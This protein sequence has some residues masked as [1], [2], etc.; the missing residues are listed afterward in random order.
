M[1]SITTGTFL[2]ALAKSNLLSTEQLSEIQ[3]EVVAVGTD[4]DP[5]TVARSLIKRGFLTRW[6]AEQL[7]A[8]H[9]NLFLGKYKLLERIG[10]GGMGTVYKAEHTVMDRTVAL[11]VMAQSMLNDPEAVA[12]F[13]REVQAA[14][15]LQHP[16]IVSAYDADCVGKTHFLVME[17]VDGD[18]LKERLQQ[19]GRLSVSWVC[20][21]IRQAALGLQHAHEHGM[22]HRDIKP[23]NLLVTTDKTDGPPTVKILDMGLARFVSNVKEDGGLTKSGQV[24]GTPDYIAPEQAEDTKHADIRADI[25]S[26]G[27]TLFHLL[28]AQVPYQGETMMNKLMARIKN[29]APPVRSLRSDVPEA[30]DA[31]IAKMLETNPA[32][33]Q[34]TPAEVATALAPFAAAIDTAFEET[35]S[36]TDIAVKT[37]TVDVTISQPEAETG[38]SEL[39]GQLADVPDH[40]QQ[41]VHQRAR[42]RHRSEPKKKGSEQTDDKSSKR[43][44]LRVLIGAGCAGIL[45]LGALAAFVLPRDSTPVATVEPAEPAP[46]QLL[47]G[48]GQYLTE[49]D[50]PF[51]VEPEASAETPT[52][53]TATDTTSETA[54]P[55]DK[56]A[57]TSE[58]S[59]ASELEKKI[60]GAAAEIPT[61]DATPTVPSPEAAHAPQTLVVGVGE[62][63]VP[64]LKT[65]FEQ[66]GPGDTIL[67]RHRGP[68]EFNPIDLNGKTPLTIVG[69]TDSNGTDFWPIVRQ[70]LLDPKDETQP[71]EAAGLFHGDQMN[72]TL[73]K[74]HLAVAGPKRADIGSVFTMGNG[75]LELDECTVTVGVQGVPGD[76]IG[77][78]MPLVHCSSTADDRVELVLRRTFLRGQRLQTCLR[79]AGTTRL[80]ISGTQTT[81]AGGPSPWIVLNEPGGEIEVSLTNCTAYNVPSL[82]QSRAADE[83]MAGKPRV[84]VESQKCLF[85]GPYANKEPFIA[86]NSDDPTS[87]LTR[88]AADGTMRWHGAN[89]VFHRY[90]SYFADERVSGTSALRKW[91][92]LWGQSGVGMARESDPIFRV[93]PDGFELQETYARDLQPRFWRN[94]NRA[95]RVEETDI[96]ANHDDI[97][98]ALSDVHLRQLTPPELAGVPRG[99]ARQLRVHQE[100]GPYQTLEA[101][102]ADLRNGDIIEIADDGV[103]VPKRDFQDNPGTGIFVLDGK[104]ATVRAA[105]GRRPLII[106]DERPQE[107]LPAAPLFLFNVT[108]AS[109]E[110]EGLHFAFNTGVRQCRLIQ[111]NDAGA[112]RVSQCSL[113]DPYQERVTP[114]D[115]RANHSA[116]LH[117]SIGRLWWESNVVLRRN[118]TLNTTHYGGHYT[119]ARNCLVEGT[120]L[121][122]PQ[123]TQSPRPLRVVHCSI[124]GGAA[125]TTYGIGRL[126]ETEVSDSLVAGECLV[127]CNYAGDLSNLLWKGKNNVLVAS[128]AFLEAQGEELRTWEDWRKQWGREGSIGEVSLMP[129]FEGASSPK[130]PY[131]SY[132][133][134]KNH[135]GARMASDGGPVGVR[136]EYLPDLPVLPPQFFLPR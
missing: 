30:L 128:K 35:I 95:Q 71:T 59:L 74:L 16:N 45:L 32:D 69:D 37:P 125:V 23:S 81:W 122:I 98:R 123:R 106:F 136:F 3:N 2:T 1:P 31:A 63:E 21:C 22:V 111:H 25:F 57:A 52:P 36:V 10:K 72:L 44:W 116:I 64:D 114:S 66:A 7:L 13:H 87:G 112:I 76:V 47:P 27:C 24:M 88:A 110:L 9:S 92:T 58:S 101:A 130:D 42:K 90:T 67:I 86:W 11:K 78:P 102:F 41:R 94:K 105:E 18:D 17:Y 85:V 109:L 91:R 89:N 124:L 118:G 103:Y 49:S 99:K 38:M 61:T 104:T 119:L 14:A 117:T 134:K 5:R 26:L 113:R 40:R 108:N 96:G 127:T 68:L 55:N 19:T 8:G 54:E 15:A 46:T 50:T 77:K 73:R 60:A 12:R 4:S 120:F 20:E 65:A 107:S 135:P 131:R 33:R 129:Q 80:G 83:T 70:I 100:D 132:R 133:L 121:D 93:W 39:L 97:P 6:Q 75:R 126:R 53:E 34:Q 115:S 56:E 79:S 29:A 84:N 48:M 28:T 82:L 43:I 62:G 51:A